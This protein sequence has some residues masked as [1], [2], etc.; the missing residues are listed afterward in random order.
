MSGET[1][2]RCVCGKSKRFPLCDGSHTSEQW[3]CAEPVQWT[4]YACVA[5]FRYQNLARKL[6]SHFK[7]V[8]CLSPTHPLASSPD[9]NHVGTLITVV[10]GSDVDFALGVCERAVADT[11]IVCCVEVSPAAL[12][13]RFP[14]NTIFIDL[15]CNVDDVSMLFSKSVMMVEQAPT[16]V[17]RKNSSAQ[18]VIECGSAEESAVYEIHRSARML[19]SAFVSHAVADEAAIAPMLDTLRRVYHADMFV[20][21]DSIDV[22]A[23][24]QR[25]IT[26]ALA[27]KDV[28]VLLLS[29]ASKQSHFCSFEV[30]AALGM[31]K[32]LRIISL[33]GT[34]PPPFV[35]HVHMLDARRDA[36]A[37]PW[38]SLHD[39]VTSHMVAALSPPSSLERG[40]AGA[41]AAKEAV[42]LQSM[43]REY[44]SMFEG[45][46]TDPRWITVALSILGLF[47]LAAV[48]LYSTA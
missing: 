4:P 10:D 35:Q 16:L 47:V 30:G 33:D 9:T 32:P 48:M 3:T 22:G 42:D 38:L 2:Q 27:E 23:D 44:S 6:A 36:A 21:A 19:R 37:R 14:P 7:G 12:A 25:A 45:T 28:F 43:L 13:A 11:R 24:W 20:C 34:L 15:T 41:A 29:E 31:G 5:S 46:H 1:S 26:E 39:V 18:V 8:L 40:P 17:P